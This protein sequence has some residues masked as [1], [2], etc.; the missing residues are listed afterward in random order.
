MAGAGEGRSQ[1]PVCAPRAE[2]PEPRPRPGRSV[3]ERGGEALAAAE[4]PLLP[5]AGLGRRSRT[6]PTLLS[7]ALDRVGVPVPRGQGRAGRAPAP[8]TRSARVRVPSESPM[9]PSQPL[10][11]TEA[12]PP[13]RAACVL[14]GHRLP[15][16]CQ[17]RARAGPV[18]TL[19][20]GGP[21]GAGQRWRLRAGA[22]LPHGRSWALGPRP[23]TAPSEGWPAWRTLNPDSERPGGT[24]SPLWVRP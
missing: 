6:Y 4:T 13:A 7:P 9:R 12:T 3:R 19:W 17:P 5:R 20:P 8:L 22:S 18:A 2:L 14:G 21:A 24:G 1:A 10:P 11:S 15:G 16:S 23:R